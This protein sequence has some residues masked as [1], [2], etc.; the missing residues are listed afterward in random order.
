MCQC[1]HKNFTG[2]NFY[3]YSPLAPPKNPQNV[4][5]LNKVVFLAQKC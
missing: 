4:V 5:F 2:G 3:A 1:H